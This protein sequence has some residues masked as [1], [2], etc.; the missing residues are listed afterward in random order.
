MVWVT[1][2]LLIPR[3]ARWRLP[4]M[5]AAALACFLAGLS[6]P[7]LGVHY[8]SDVIAGWCFGLFWLLLLLRLTAAPLRSPRPS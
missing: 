5:L 4:A 6:R 3:E 2:A 1:L 8:P 7:M